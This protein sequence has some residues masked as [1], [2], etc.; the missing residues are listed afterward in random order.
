MRWKKSLQN[1]KTR[2]DHFEYNKSYSQMMNINAVKYV[3]LFSNDAA[4][5]SRGKF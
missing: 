5:F 3:K 4:F 2:C 1:N